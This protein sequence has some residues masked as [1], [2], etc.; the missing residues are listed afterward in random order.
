MHWF[1]G[2]EDRMTYAFLRQ[3]KRSLED[4]LLYLRENRIPFREGYYSFMCGLLGK[5]PDYDFWPVEVKFWNEYLYQSTQRHDIA[6]EEFLK[7]SCF[8]PGNDDEVYSKF[9]ELGWKYVDERVEAQKVAYETTRDEDEEWIDLTEFNPRY[10]DSCENRPC[11]CSTPE[12]TRLSIDY[13]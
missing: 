13:D 10:C 11:I 9:V 6:K 4:L 3:E 12:R 2:I 5:E 8:G 1:K 7:S